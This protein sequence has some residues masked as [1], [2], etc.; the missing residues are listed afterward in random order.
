LAGFILA[1]LNGLLKPVLKFLSTP[2]IYLTLGAFPLVI[3]IGILWLLQYF[4]PELKIDGFW[5]YFWSIIIISVVNW[6][7]DIIVKNKP[8]SE[9][10][11]T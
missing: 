8:L 10:I 9:A 4:I 1:L 3:N 5:A 6:M 7:F 11:E 2:L